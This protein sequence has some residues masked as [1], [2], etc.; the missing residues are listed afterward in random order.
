[1]LTLAQNNSLLDAAVLIPTLPFLAMLVCGVLC[2][3]RSRAAQVA[4]A[5]VSLGAV[6]GAFVV[7]LIVFAGM[8]DQAM[9]HGA[10]VH[11]FQWINIGDFSGD[12][13]FFIDTLTIVM[14]MVVTGVGSLITLY[15]IGYMSGDPG[16]TRFFTYIA[17]FIF[18][19]TCLVMADNLLLLYLGWEGVGLASYLLIG[20]YYRKP[21][22]AAAAKKA[23][24]V[25]RIGDFGFALG[26]MG[27]F[28]VF[29]SIEFA[30]ILPTAREIGRGV[31]VAGGESAYESLGAALSGA[32][33]ANPSVWL[34]LWIPFLLMLGAF[35]K[36]AQLPLHVWL[37]DAMEGP[38]PVSALIH[39]ATMVT[40]GVYMIARLIPIFTLSPY[41]LPTVAVVGGCTALFAATVALC[42]YD[43]KRVWAY[44][45][46]SQIGY[47]FLGVGVLGTFGA[48][49][50]LFTHAFFKALL[51]L[52]AGSVM[53]A[54]AG[55]LDLRKLSGMGRV[56]PV[57]AGL[58]LVGCLALAGFPFTAG[59]Y[60][61]DQILTDALAAF[62]VMG[63]IGI[64]TAY[65][66]AFYTFRVWFRVFMGPTEY[67]MGREH[68]GYP[69]GA[70]IH[71]E[72][73]HADAEERS[74]EQAGRAPVVGG[75]DH[76]H[77]HEG[78]GH[79]EPHEAPWWPMNAPLV[80]LAVGA[81]LAGIFSN[82]WMEYMIAGSTA[83][84]PHHG[85]HGNLHAI[86]SW[87]AGLGAVAMIALAGYFHWWRRDLSERI[88]ERASG[89]I[90]FLYRAW[91][92]DWA[93]NTF[94]RGGLRAVAVVCDL[95]DSVLVD[96][97]MINT[98]FGRTP[99]W[100]G[101][102]G[103]RLQR[104]HLQGYALKM[105]VGLAVIVLLIVWKVVLG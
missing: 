62:P 7:T 37:P 65:L 67:E 103:R 15:A 99:R 88:A 17:L 35:G 71:G 18:A 86:V 56:M 33:L 48:V 9:H 22:A 60:S 51:F 40:A 55:Q 30:E 70:G 28:T 68:H 14:L 59:F 6:A 4:A 24:I 84:V 38:T 50:H 41:A 26:L 64:I 102:A 93:Y 85:E 3:F 96:G 66:T 54:M 100:V 47:M 42:Q 81:L 1:M 44:S 95:F 104:G 32:G 105:S 90:R 69:I 58:T 72:A 12:F 20:F 74:A 77:E 49:F 57:T 78:G 5:C 10:S 36:S 98:L 76:D 21:S 73:E 2:W 75:V 61:K 83:R 25:N 63:V 19:M 92:I 45:T 31:E 34:V 13:S 82:D 91:Y 46:I 16:F 80:V 27:I 39:A 97:L 101:S 94:I 23:F 8:N 29:G 11:F 79:G 53:H 43:I 52:T 89:G 87:V